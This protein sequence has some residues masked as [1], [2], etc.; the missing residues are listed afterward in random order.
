MKPR[1]ENNSSPKTDALKNRSAPIE[2]TDKLV[3]RCQMFDGHSMWSGRRRIRVWR[4]KKSSLSLVKRFLVKLFT[5]KIALVSGS[6]AFSRITI[7][8]KRKTDFHFD[9]ALYEWKRT[10]VNR[11]TTRSR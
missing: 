4:A 1:F 8:P 9:A 11:N 10:N 5:K 7:S 2:N 3:K 6:E